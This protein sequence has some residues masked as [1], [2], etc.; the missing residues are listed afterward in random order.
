MLDKE[1]INKLERAKAQATQTILENIPEGILQNALKGGL[2]TKKRIKN[3][4]KLGEQ[5]YERYSSATV[6]VKVGREI[7]ANLGKLDP[8]YARLVEKV[9]QLKKE[10]SAE[11]V[12]G[13]ITVAQLGDASSIKQ[14]LRVAEEGLNVVKRDVLNRLAKEYGFQT[15]SQAKNLAEYHQSSLKEAK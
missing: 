11:K 6:V 15:Y 13:G 5:E 12:I 8:D 1:N 3:M 2:N 10:M 4:L 14:K 7:F 9:D